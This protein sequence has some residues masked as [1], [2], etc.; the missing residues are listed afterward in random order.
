[1]RDAAM[2]CHG[3]RTLSN[4]I[5]ADDCQQRPQKAQQWSYDESQRNMSEATEALEREEGRG[6]RAHPL[7][8]STF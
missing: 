5:T 3:S 1:M 7:L 4:V 6:I 8:Y 2:N